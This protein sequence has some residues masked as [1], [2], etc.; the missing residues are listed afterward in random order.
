MSVTNL[1][2][3]QLP[4][5]RMRAVGS[6]VLRTEDPRLLTGRGNY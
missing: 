2:P 6:R 3:G 5:L 4:P 1:P